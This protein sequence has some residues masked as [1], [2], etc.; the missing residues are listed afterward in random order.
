M[1]RI[2]SLVI[3]A[4]FLICLSGVA[5]AR[6]GDSRIG[7]ITLNSVYISDSNAHTHVTTS[8]TDVYKISF[9]AGTNLAWV[10]ILDSNTTGASDSIGEYVQL[11]TA[12]SANR[13]R[14]DVG[15]A[16]AGDWVHV[17]F[18]DIPLHCKFGLM[19]GLGA[20]SSAGADTADGTDGSAVVYYRT[21]NR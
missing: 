8:P 11:I 2:F 13:I 12:E 17:D 16:T 19:V 20:T 9:R 1:K 7:A 21:S 18:G 3:V 10:T 14:A 5:E 15:E 4:A 6:V